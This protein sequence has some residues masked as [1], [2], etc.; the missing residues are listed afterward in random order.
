VTARLSKRAYRPATVP[1]KGRA[2]APEGKIIVRWRPRV[3]NMP[4]TWPGTGTGGARGPSVRP[5]YARDAH[6]VVTSDCGS[7]CALNSARAT[8][9]RDHVRDPRLRAR[10]PTSL[11]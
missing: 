2:E 11:P 1:T 5:R 4:R 9:G 3:P 8:C 6:L 10:L 7:D